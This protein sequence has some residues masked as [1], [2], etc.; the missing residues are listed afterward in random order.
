MGESQNRP[1]ESTP[2]DRQ[3]VDQVLRSVTQDLRSLQQNLVSQLSQDISRLQAERSRLQTEIDTLQTQ[4]SQLQSEHEVLLSQQQQAQQKVWAKQLAQALAGHLYQILSQRLTADSN[5]SLPGGNGN[6]HTSQTLMALD[7]TLNQALVSLQQDL[8]SYHSSLTQQ[9][10][11]MQSLEKQ[12]EVLLE[13]LVSRLSDRLQSELARIPQDSQSFP[14]GPHTLANGFR[15]E[16]PSYPTDTPPPSNG[17][18]STYP[19]TSPPPPPPPPPQ[20]VRSIAVIPPQSASRSGSAPRFNVAQQGLILILLSTLALS[21]HNVVVRIVSTEQT[22]IFGVFNLSRS[23]ELKSLDA[24]LLILWLRM[25]V[26]VPVMMGIASFL[27]P[28]SWRDIKSFTL[29]RDP[30]LIRSV[31]GS[32]VFLFL[33]QVLIYIAIASIGPGVAVTILFMYPLITV[34]L[35]WFLFGDRP[36]LIRWLVMAT[37]LFGVVLTTLPRLTVTNVS[38]WGIFSAI[39][40]GIFFA[41][42]LIAMQISFRK[43]HPVPVSVVQFITIFVLTS[44][45]LTIWFP[46]KEPPNNLLGLLLGGIVLGSLTLVGYLL[47]NL[48]VK[49]LGAARASIIAASGPVLTALLAFFITADELQA[50][51]WLGIILVTTGILGLSF[52]RMFLQAR[53]QNGR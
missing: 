3:A 45:M 31:I 27:Y 8:N 6:G 11:R 38:Q 18:R 13:T 46:V 33:S 48:G 42:Y 37:I 14:T 9:L 32:G 44:V 24:A 23:I 34:P 10:D 4:N 49:R 19:T 29:S 2:N 26:V 17:S 51:Q 41:L 15:V 40:S 7:E 20:M 35:A 30:R 28:A 21:L 22:S 5:P 53:P 25:L 52:E 43:L 39:L 50:V 12:G 1:P 47:N 36:S 16:P